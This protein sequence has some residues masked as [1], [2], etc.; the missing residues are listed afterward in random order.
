MN[1]LAKSLPQGKLG[2]SLLALRKITVNHGNN[3]FK[4]VPNQASWICNAWRSPLFGTALPRSLDN[5]SCNPLCNPSCNPSCSPSCQD[6]RLADCRITEKLRLCKSR[7]TARQQGAPA[8]RLVSAH[9]TSTRP[10]KQNWTMCSRLIEFCSEELKVT[11]LCHNIHQCSKFQKVVFDIG[12]IFWVRL[13]EAT[14]V[15]LTIG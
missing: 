2:L 14:S 6:C 1:G 5:P 10:R 9:S 7:V 12:V 8:T 11:V 15:R 3:G 13:K 4:M